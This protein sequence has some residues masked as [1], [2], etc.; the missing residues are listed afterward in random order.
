MIRQIHIWYT[1]L[2]ISAQG[3]P[4]TLIATDRLPPGLVSPVSTTPTESIL[5]LISN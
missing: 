3:G 5:L 2:F 4:C 1:L